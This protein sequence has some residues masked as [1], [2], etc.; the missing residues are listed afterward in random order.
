MVSEVVV[1]GFSVLARSRRKEQEVV[2]L[3]FFVLMRAE[4]P[5]WC[6][7]I[8]QRLPVTKLLNLAT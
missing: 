4:P 3:R 2:D 6:G 7:A 5:A 1:E 8:T